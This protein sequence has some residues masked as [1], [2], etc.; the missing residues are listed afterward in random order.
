VDR[1]ARPPHVL[2]LV[3]V[4]MGIGCGDPEG[5]K[6]PFD[7]S[8]VGGSTGGAPGAGVGGASG[9]G[10]GPTGTAGDTSTGAAG[11]AGAIGT[12]VAGTT[13]VGGAVGLAGASGGAGSAGVA[14]MAGA[15]GGG[16]AGSTGMAGAGGA[17]GAAG[18]AGGAGSAGVAG[19]TGAAGAAGTTGSAGASG[20][21]GTTGSAGASGAAGTTG[22]AGVSGA[23]GRPVTGAC[24]GKVKTAA[25]VIDTFEDGST[26]GWYEY[27][28]STA[29]STLAPLAIATPGATGTT[30]AL[31]LSGSGF[32]GFG[33]GMGFMMVCTDAS[34]FQGITFWAKGTSGTSNDIALQVAIP[35]TQAT[36]DLG[37]CTSK[38]FD[39]P[40]KKVLL[41]AG[42]QQYS[43]KFTDLA[44]AGFGNPA[45][46]AGIV[47]AINFVSIEGPSLDFQVD[48]ISF[49]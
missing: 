2:A 27:K 34:A 29:G 49:F 14:G 30:K 8:G 15:A 38:C 41:G 16:S 24:A 33:A 32:Q 26:T 39:H 19:T 23:A 13:G 40:S 18:S 7:A 17:A 11:M 25:A 4:T 43:V 28:D 42:W 48:E 22:S 3:L 46:Y 6:R 31:R 44:Q 1:V 36:A 37:D 45:S 47:M 9:S 12:G 5:F 35:E 20:A 21:A 10:S